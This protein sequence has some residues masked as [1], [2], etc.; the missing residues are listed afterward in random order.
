M[1]L[2]PSTDNQVTPASE[3]QRLAQDKDL[4]QASQPF[5]RILCSLSL[6]LKLHGQEAQLFYASITPVLIMPLGQPPNGLQAPLL[7]HNPCWTRQ[8]KCPFYP[9][10]EQAAFLLRAFG[11]FPLSQ[12][13]SPTSSSCVKYFLALDF[14]ALPEALVPMCF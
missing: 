12:A 8:S 4:H 6:N 7:T 10:G 11:F 13:C 5:S 1:G 3:S 14:L 2:S 9:T